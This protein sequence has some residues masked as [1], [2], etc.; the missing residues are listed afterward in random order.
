MSKGSCGFYDYLIR[1]KREPSERKQDNAALLKQIIDTFEESGKRYGSPCIH[2]ELR[3]GDRPSAEPPLAVTCALC[4]L[5]FEAGQI[6]HA[7]HARLMRRAGL[8]AVP[9]RK[10]KRRK[11]SEVSSETVNL[12]VPKPCIIKAN[13]VWYSDITF[14]KT[15]E[16]WELGPKGR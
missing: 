7:G 2:A 9:E 16:G 3:T 5:L 6:P 13:Q 10:Y 15:G 8:Y 14:M 11:A 4:G 1:R 12:L